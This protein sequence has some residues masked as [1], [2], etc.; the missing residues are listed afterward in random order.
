M[1]SAICFKLDQSKILLS[2]N[3]LKTLEFM[4]LTLYQTST[5]FDAA[6]E[7]L[8]EKMVGKGENAG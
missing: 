1:S 4:Y 6:T 8:F 3:G 5:S 7:K 2:S